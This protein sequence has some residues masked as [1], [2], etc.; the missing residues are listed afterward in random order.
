MMCRICTGYRQTEAGRGIC[1]NRDSDFW[2][3]EMPEDGKCLDYEEEQED[4]NIEKG[5]LEGV[6][7][8]CV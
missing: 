3:Q 7:D 4:R 1:T 8:H 2:D 6:S 5:H